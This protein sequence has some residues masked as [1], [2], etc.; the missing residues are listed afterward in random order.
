MK[1]GLAAVVLLVLAGLGLKWVLEERARTTPP[2]PTVNV[3]SA[4]AVYRAAPGHQKHVGEM[5]LDCVACHQVVDGGADSPG[6]ERCAS[7]HAE[8]ATLHHGLG[9][10]TSGG[11]G[12]GGVPLAQCTACHGFGP[13]PDQMPGDCLRCH[14]E[15]QGRIPAVTVHA[16][17][18]CLSCHVPHEDRVQARN[19]AECHQVQVQHGGD[20]ADGAGAACI[21]CHDPHAEAAVAS[22]RCAACH[23]EGGALP[24]PATAG[25]ADRGCA[26]CHAGHRFTR[27]TVAPCTSCHAGVHALEGKGH[28]EC[29]ACHDPHGLSPSGA[30]ADRCTGCHRRV[31]ATHGSAHAGAGPTE[32]TG[33]HVP[34]PARGEPDRTT[35]IDCHAL[36]RTEQQAHG[37]DVAC[38]QCHAPHQFVANEARA[39]A[40]CHAARLRK[41]ARHPGHGECVTCHDGL[42]HVAGR[43][44][45][46]CSQC[47][48]EQQTAVIEGHAACAQCHEPHAVGLPRVACAGCHEPQA[49]A[50]GPGHAACG[51]CHD[52]HSGERLAGVSDCSSCHQAKRLPGLHAVAKHQDCASCHSVHGQQ[53]P[54]SRAGCLTCHTEQ[55]GHQPEA[56]RCS[57]C[58]TFRA[59]GARRTRR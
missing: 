45:Q 28:R 5:A 25:H 2:G 46:A 9:E 50:V 37:G 3:Q 31:S 35:C 20:R 17:D 34:H 52:T 33:C 21:T 57:G 38:A 54:A 22:D 30:A 11:T 14:A 49:S 26:A 53:D 8:L 55:Q 44:P 12:D 48:A 15:A 6:P 23:G 4:W 10:G 59:P 19:C 58:H 39:C 1:W 27:E 40:S 32:C 43:D 51:N 47:H 13:D 36:A 24:V 41:L 42:P 16:E 7:C 18:D 56:T 29:V